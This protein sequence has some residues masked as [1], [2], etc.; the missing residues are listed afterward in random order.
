MAITAVRNYQKTWKTV[1]FT[2]PRKIQMLP[3]PQTPGFLYAKRREMELANLHKDAT[4]S[5]LCIRNDATKTNTIKDPTMP[6]T[7]CPNLRIS[8][9]I[10]AYFHNTGKAILIKTAEMH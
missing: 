4:C 1:T 8:V 7:S 5:H 3:I 6:N 10:C 2:F 9:L